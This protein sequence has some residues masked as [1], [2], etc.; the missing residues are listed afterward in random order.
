[1]TFS[2]SFLLG[3]NR[4]VLTNSRQHLCPVLWHHGGRPPPIIFSYRT[5]QE[6][7]SIAKPKR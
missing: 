5:K 4:A 1:M 2:D 7:G 3:L 6:T